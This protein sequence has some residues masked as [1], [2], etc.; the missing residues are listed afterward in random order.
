[1]AN[2]YFR[3]RHKPDSWELKIPDTARITDEEI[4]SFVENIK[5]VILL[6]MFSKKNTHEV[7]HAFRQLAML[8]PELI[9]PPLL[10]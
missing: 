7:V 1:M 8:R 9:I 5:P 4:T 3:E 10:D 2:C 6:A